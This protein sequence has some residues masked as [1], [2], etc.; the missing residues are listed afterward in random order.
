MYF[1]RNKRSILLR[2][3]E[4]RLMIFVALLELAIVTVV[5]HQLLLTLFSG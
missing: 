4:N 3:K 1:R 2:I 5:S